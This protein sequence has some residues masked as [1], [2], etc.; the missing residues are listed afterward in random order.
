MKLEC[1]AMMISFIMSYVMIKVVD[2]ISVLVVPVGM[3]RIDTYTDI[4]TLTFRTG[5]CTRRTGMYWLI[6]GNTGR[7]RAYQ[8][9]QIFFFFQFCNF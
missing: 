4:E 6:L 9:V 1:L 8:P 5:L 7:Y 2:T 3:Y